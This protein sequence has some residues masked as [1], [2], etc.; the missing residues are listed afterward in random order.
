MPLEDDAYLPLFLTDT[1]YAAPNRATNV[2]KPEVKKEE[3]APYPSPSEDSPAMVAEETPAATVEPLEYLGQNQKKVTILVQYPD[4]TFLPEEH[5]DFL[6]KILA[7]VKLDWA[8]VAL[9]NVQHCPTDHPDWATLHPQQVVSFGVDHEWVANCPLYQNTALSNHVALR[10]E[11]LAEIAA[12]R[13]RKGQLWNALKAL[14]P[15]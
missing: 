3:P 5:K 15:A 8:D 6:G 14:F 11:G 7:A 13:N 12:D 1:L 10:A 4:Q 9:L 2:P